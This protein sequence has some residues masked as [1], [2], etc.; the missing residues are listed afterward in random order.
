[1]SHLRRSATLAIAA[2]AVL[3]AVGAPGAPAVPG[4]DAAG[5]AAGGSPEAEPAVADAEAA[6]AL[7]A[8]GAKHFRDGEYALALG[9]LERSH[10]LLPSPNTLL[11]IA[12]TLDRLGRPAQAL[13]RFEQAQQQA[14]QQVEAGE[15]RYEKTVEAAAKEGAAVR[16]KLASLQIMVRKA[17]AGTEIEIAGQRQ[18]L[19]PDGKLSLWQPPGSVDIVV[20]PPGAD[21]VERT[22][23]LRAGGDAFLEI[24]MSH[25]DKPP[26]PPPPPPPESGSPWV[27][28][29]I[30]ATGV[31]LVGM[32][33]FAG[34]GLSASGIRSDLEERCAPS[35]GPAD[36]DDRD[37]GEQ[38]ATIANISAIV[39]GVGLAVG[40][41]FAMLAMTDGG[42]EQ[43]GQ[44][45][46]AALV[47]GPQGVSLE[48][49]F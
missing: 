43:P 20:H 9:A 6:R 10:Q 13:E 44:A 16:A 15:E 3:W 41:T 23:S 11:L 36:Q 14:R 22:L 34:F 19:P 8:D 33:L 42:D 48:G 17:P 1:M 31:G 37:T 25:P 46:A 32:G 2:A 49:R 47:V 45:P 39:G 28:P 29:A 30:V 24:D 18:A 40:L 27:A 7:F 21:A 26:P 35:C 38:N 5:G 12:R 4:E